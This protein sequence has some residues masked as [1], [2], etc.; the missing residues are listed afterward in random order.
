MLYN[1][2]DKQLTTTILFNSGSTVSL[3]DNNFAIALG[4]KGYLLKTLLYKACDTKP[5]S[6][7]AMHY[8][9]RM[10]DKSGN[11]FI[12][13]MIGV[14]HV[15]QAQELPNFDN[16]RTIFPWLPEGSIEHPK[17]KIGILLGQNVNILLP[18]EY[19]RY[20]NVRISKSRLGDYGYIPDGSHESLRQQG[21][22][23]FHTCF[24]RIHR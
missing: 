3:I 13:C 19:V 20:G 1:F 16:I 8:N 22:P 15:C 17:M 6:T 18:E 10:K 21:S 9:V 7:Q 4:L 5:E 23:S 11:I 24:Y 12:I 14:K 2:V